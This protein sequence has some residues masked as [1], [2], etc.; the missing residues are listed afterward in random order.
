MIRFFLTLGLGIAIG[1]FGVAGTIHKGAEVVT[2]TADVADSM[3]KKINSAK[4]T[5]NETASSAKSLTDKVK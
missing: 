4:K 3:T 2:K 1:A 5:V